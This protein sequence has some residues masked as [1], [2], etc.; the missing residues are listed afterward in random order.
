MNSMGNSKLFKNNYSFLWFLL[1]LI[2]MVSIHFLGVAQGNEIGSDENEKIEN[3]QNDNDNFKDLIEK[4]NLN[5]YY[6]FSTSGISSHYAHAFH[7]RRTS[8]GERFDMFE[9][10]A[11]HRS[12]PFGTILKVTNLSNGKTTLVKINDRGPHIKRRIL[13]LSYASAK[14]IDGLGLA[15]VKV[16]GFLQGKHN[17]FGK[18]KKRYFYAYSLTND[19]VCIPAD[20]VLAIDSSNDFQEIYEKLKSIANTTI[21]EN[22]YLLVDADNISPLAD[23]RYYLARVGRIRPD[24]NLSSL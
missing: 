20:I 9:N 24:K 6:L 15:R 17:I 21:N 1:P 22:V 7:K 13:D 10:T 19:P 3:T 23:T 18:F 4:T 5:S 8:S 12:L 16:E 11:A 2:A 14:E